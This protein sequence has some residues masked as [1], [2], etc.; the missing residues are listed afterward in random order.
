[1]LY[2]NAPSRPLFSVLGIPVT[3]SVWH[4]AL[5]LMLVMMPLNSVKDWAIHHALGM[6]FL[7]SFSVLL[8]E[9]GHA[10]VSLK[11]RLQPE[12]VLTG[13]GGVTRHLPASRPRDEFLIV[14]AGPSMNFALSAVLWALSTLPALAPMA[15][16]LMWGSI[17]NLVWALYNLLPILPMDGGLLLRVILRKVIKSE[18]RADR[19]A[20]G[21]GAVLGGAVAMYGLVNQW[22]F[23]A[24]FLGFSAWEN[25]QRMRALGTDVNTQAS[26]EHDRVRELLDAART[27]FQANLFEEAM[28]ACHQ[29]RAEP[30]LS[31][32]EQQHVWHIL[33]VSAARLQSWEEALRYAERVPGSGDMAQ[34][35]AA[36]LL[37][38]GEP[39]RV[40][41]FLSTPTALLLPQDRI[42]ALQEVARAG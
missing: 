5:I 17:I 32:D 39:A 35:Q 15:W 4:L 42:F 36:A 40:K 34:I 8:H 9:M 38:L 18:V 2:D 33:A 28:R 37:A 11:L 19:M 31:R 23:V 30:F 6:M 13:L 14:A 1:M 26:Q 20:Y 41:R 27:A 16:F 3:I 12:I 10:L 7:A 29:A 25:W 24:L 22:F 21:T